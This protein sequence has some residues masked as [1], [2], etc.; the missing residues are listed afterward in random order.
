MIK[1]RANN[2]GFTI[3]ELLISMA[4]FSFL[5]LMVTYGFVQINRSY[6]RGVTTKTI[7]ETA[8][9]VVEDITRGVRA[10]DGDFDF[11]VGV[12]GG[13]HM[14]ITD[15][16]YIWNMHEDDGT[17]TGDTIYAPTAEK[18]EDTGGEIVMVKARDGRGCADPVNESDAEVILDSRAAVQFLSFQPVGDNSYALSITVSTK[19]AVDG[20]LEIFGSNARCK[21]QIGDQ[22]C[23][24]AKLDTVVQT[25]N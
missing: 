21:V 20:D 8:R 24:V 14:C 25:R 3:V 6:T 2:K 7:Q 9:N 17:P 23:D 4:F 12:D 13:Y 1:L 16:R 22:F 11:V 15:T 10:T 18:Y 19:K 5:L